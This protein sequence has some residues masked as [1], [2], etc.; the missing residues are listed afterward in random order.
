MHSGDAERVVVETLGR[1][2]WIA[3]HRE[4][5]SHLKQDIDP[6]YKSFQNRWYR[7]FIRIL[8]RRPNP[9]ASRLLGLFHA[10]ET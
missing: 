4:P 1:E 7:T 9:F 10:V 6:K 5:K 3:K 8:Q 2:A